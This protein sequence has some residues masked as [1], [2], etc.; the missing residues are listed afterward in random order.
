[1]KKIISTLLLSSIVVSG[2]SVALAAEGDNVTN[3]NKEETANIKVNGSLGADNTKPDTKIPEGDKDWINVDIPTKTIFYNTAKDPIVKSPNYTIENKSG[4][5]VE[6]SIASFIQDGSDV[7]PNDFDLNL[8]SKTDGAETDSILVK[9]GVALTTFDPA[10]VTLANSE[11]RLTSTGEATMPNKLS[12]RYSGKANAANA[13]NVSYNLGL[14][15]KS[16]AW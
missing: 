12:F 11:K 14:K 2:A 9:D 5:P 13:V 4:R 1:M 7:V 10:L 16:V 8:T 6:V 15:F 3:I